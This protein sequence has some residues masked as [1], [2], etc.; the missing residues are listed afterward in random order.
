MRQGDT[1]SQN[2]FE[3][4]IND[5]TNILDVD[6]DAV[7]LENFYINFLMYADESS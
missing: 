2:L 5:L 1:L 6:Y 4:F 3:I 7:S